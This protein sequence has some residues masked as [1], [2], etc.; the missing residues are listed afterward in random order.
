ML[1]RDLI[2]LLEGQDRGAEVVVRVNL[3]G[4]TD[5]DSGESLIED[6]SDLDGEYLDVVD[7]R[8]VLVENNRVVIIADLVEA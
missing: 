5:S 8:S 1:V 7:E 3:E 2:D 6:L 4:A